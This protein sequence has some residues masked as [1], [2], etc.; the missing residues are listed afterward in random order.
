MYITYGVGDENRLPEKLIPHLSG[1]NL[2]YRAD[3]DSRV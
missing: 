2:Y 1:H 3:R